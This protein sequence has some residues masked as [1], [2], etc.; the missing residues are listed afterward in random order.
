MFHYPQ[1]NSNSAQEFYND[2]LRLVHQPTL[3]YS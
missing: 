3:F 1:A 2:K